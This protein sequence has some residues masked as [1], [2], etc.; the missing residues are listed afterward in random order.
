[1]SDEIGLR[2][3]ELTLRVSCAE[4]SHLAWLREFLTPWFD[5]VPASEGECEVAVVADETEYGRRLESGPLGAGA[6]AHCFSL[7]N[8]AVHLPLWKSRPTERMAFDRRL[9]VF[10]RIGERGRRVEVLGRPRHLALRFAAMR[11]IRELALAQAR[12]SDRL[13]VHAAALEMDGRTVLIAGPKGAGKTSLLIASLLDTAA[14]FV[15]NDR[16]VV[17]LDPHG[18]TAHGMPTLV[19]IRKPTLDA[20]PDVRRRLERSGYHHLDSLAESGGHREP[21]RAER[22]AIDLSPA[23]LCVLLDTEPAARGRVSALLFPQSYPPGATVRPARLDV[24][25]AAE[26]LSGALL[27]GACA[28][29][30]QSFFA[31]ALAQRAV[32]PARRDGTQELAARVP[33]FDVRAEAPASGGRSAAD[34]LRNLAE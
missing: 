28:D 31:P 32:A 19:S 25:A 9:G 23:Q 29:P 16:V 15:S 11:V 2:F 4:H 33:S 14:R 10:Y 27:G 24:A 22:P 12:T 20:H 3:D 8:G 18:V 5:F 30:A 21:H 7:D 1:M 13:L 34:L 17:V 26:R 6:T